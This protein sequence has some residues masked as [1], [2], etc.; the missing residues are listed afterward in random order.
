MP[1]HEEDGSLL[2]ITLDHEVGKLV[3]GSPGL[4]P[5]LGTIYF[6]EEHRGVRLHLFVY[7]SRGSFGVVFVVDLECNGEWIA[8]RSATWPPPCIQDDKYCKGGVDAQ[9]FL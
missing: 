1:S 2:V 7:L 4:K 5:H 6:R 3:F 8:R 9:S